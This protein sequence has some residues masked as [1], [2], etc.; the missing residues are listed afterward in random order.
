M[1]NHKDKNEKGKKNNIRT[2]IIVGEQCAHEQYDG[3]GHYMNKQLSALTPFL[4]STLERKQ[5]S[6]EGSSMETEQRL[7]RQTDHKT[8]MDLSSF[9]GKEHRFSHTGLHQ[10][11]RQPGNLRAPGYRVQFSLKFWAV[12]WGRAERWTGQKASRKW[13]RVIKEKCAHHSTFW[14]GL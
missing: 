10:Y 8:N 12:L 1:I 13:Q 2:T 5:S 7:E 9:S 11:A 3:G 14:F 4:P 6:T